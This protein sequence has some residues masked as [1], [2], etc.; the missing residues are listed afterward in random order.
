MCRILLPIFITLLLVSCK[1]VF[2]PDVDN[3]K[4]ALVVQGLFTNL[5]GQLTVRLSKAL[6][7]DSAGYFE[8]VK[9]A[10]VAVYND[11]SEMYLLNGN[12]FGEYRNS[13]VRCYPGRKYFL[14]VTTPDGSI[15][16]STQQSLPELYKQDTAYSANISKTVYIPDAFG[17][18][19]KSSIQ[20]IETY[21]DLSSQDN[22]FPKCRYESR[23]TVQYLYTPPAEFI[24]P[25]YYCW[26][27]FTADANIN[28]TFT[29]FEKSIGSAPKHILGFF[30]SAIIYYD[31]RPNLTLVSF[32]LSTTKYSLT[33]EAHQYYLKVK[34]QLEASGKL[35]DPVPSQTIGN[36]KCINNPD[37]LVLGLFEVSN[38]ERLYYR[39]NLG[40]KHPVL[41]P[42]DGFPGF[43]NDGEQLNTAPPFWNK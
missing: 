17:S 4:S 21:T 6:P 42:K 37:K 20:G 13:T 3:E 16:E 22:S 28:L 18:S 27:T 33:T 34:N 40:Q 12:G 38:V 30:P 8:P 11:N 31:D 35:F 7:F 15:Y 14:R 1:D 25:V 43:T 5:E 29:K 2:E 10:I 41:E 39:Y 9:N 32:I 24:P 26:K 36:M 23:V 19:L